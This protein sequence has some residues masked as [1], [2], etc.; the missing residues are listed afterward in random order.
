MSIKY[1]MWLTYNAEKEK[2]QLPVLPESF[3][4][5]NGSSNDTMDIAG[6]GEIVIMA[7]PP[8]PAIQLFELLSGGE[9]PRIA[10]EQHYKAA[11]TGTEN[12]QVESEQETRPLYSDGLRGRP[13]LHD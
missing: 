6:L 9:I 13:L 1:Q 12:Q 4:T 7:E 11:Y 2:I 8:G 3:S 10:G 5:K